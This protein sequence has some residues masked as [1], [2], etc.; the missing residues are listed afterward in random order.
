MG[1][2]KK[3]KRHVSDT[4]TPYDDVF[5]TL[6]TDC[7]PLIIPVIN[8]IFGTHYA[9]DTPVNLDPDKHYWNR[10]SGEQQE[11]I[12]DSC[13]QLGQKRYHVECQSTL[14]HTIVVR[15]FEYDAQI[16]LASRQLEGQVLTVDFPES[17][18]LY[19]RHNSRTQDELQV[20]IRTR[21]GTVSYCIPIMKVQDYPLDEIFEKQLLFLLPFY[22]FRYEKQF[23]EKEENSRELELLA[24]DYIRIKDEIVK[25]E[26]SGKLDSYTKVSIR[27]MIEKV[28]KNLATDY[29]T[30]QEGVKSIMGGK[31]L[32]YEAK[33]IKQSGIEEGLE[34]G[35]ERGLE[36]GREQ[37]RELGQLE[38]LAIN[39]KTLM[40]KLQVSADEAMKLLDVSD[41][42][43]PKLKDLL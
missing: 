26:A 37:G 42:L 6:L 9:L 17:A 3:H 7:R 23:R 34:R 33:R 43:K 35:L 15:M 40:K 27:N 4:S 2:D 29:P 30:V 39:I 5:Y 41:V 32:D 25:L 24:N 38:N 28:V 13:F 20:R 10:Q 21:G 19:L 22:I 12:T 36:Q 14:D 31:V 16:A 8:E 1:N 11:R 18:L